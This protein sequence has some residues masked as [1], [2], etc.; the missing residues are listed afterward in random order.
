MR[1]RINARALSLLFR[2]TPYV[3][4]RRTIGRMPSAILFYFDP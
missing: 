2:P 3:A 1:E 4:G